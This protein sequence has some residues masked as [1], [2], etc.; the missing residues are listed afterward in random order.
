MTTCTYPNC[1]RPEAGEKE[2]PH[3]CDRSDDFRAHKNYPVDYGDLTNWHHPITIT[4]AKPEPSE[5]EKRVDSHSG[6]LD[7]QAG[8]IV[9]LEERVRREHDNAVDA[10]D[11]LTDRVA[12]L[13]KKDEELYD[14][15]TAKP[16][17]GQFLELS[18]RI[19]TL[20]DAQQHGRSEKTAK[21]AEPQ[22]VTFPIDD[23][24]TPSTI[25]AGCSIHDKPPAPPQSEPK[26]CESRYCMNEANGAECEEPS[27]W[28]K[29]APPPSETVRMHRDSKNFFG[30]SYQWMQCDPAHKCD[31]DEHA[32][33]QRLPAKGVSHD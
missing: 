10:H 4:P 16:S 32:T 25:V 22:P 30:S 28:P 7:W 5:M 14:Y 6:I 21:A 2:Y 18:E 12:A 27:H 3:H 13:E 1:V 23:F 33:F 9:V 17:I 15:L 26:A 11:R 31:R 8:R 24:C 29:A 20:E 19:K